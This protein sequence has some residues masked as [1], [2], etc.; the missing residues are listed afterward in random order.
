MPMSN[1]AG[2]AGWI[3]TPANARRNYSRYNTIMKVIS[4]PNISWSRVRNRQGLITKAA[5]RKTARW[6]AE[7][8]D[9]EKII[10]FGSYAYGQPDPDSDVDLLVVMPARNEIDQSVRIW[11]AVD[12]PFS[13]DVIVE[14]PRNLVWR[15]KEGDFFLREVMQRGKVLYE[16]ANQGVDAKSGSR[17]RRR[18]KTTPG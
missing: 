8:F 12:P 15:L 3:I 16:K 13:L 6:I 1:L 14:K 11:L 7:R 2:A 5:I 9:P 10:L 4:S 17:P 18:Q